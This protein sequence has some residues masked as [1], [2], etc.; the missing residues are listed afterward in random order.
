VPRVRTRGWRRQSALSLWDALT[1]FMDSGLRHVLC[2][3]IERDGALEG[4]NLEL[5]VEALRR[6]AQLQWQASGGVASGADLSA[7]SACG[8]PAAISG[9][10]LLEERISIAE[11][12]AFLPNA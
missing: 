12:K 5:Y 10:A 9:K 6:H 4:P 3:D 8:V 2:T 7:L 11:L 1:P